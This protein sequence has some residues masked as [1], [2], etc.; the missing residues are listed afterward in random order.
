[1]TPHTSYQ[2]FPSQCLTKQTPKFQKQQIVFKDDVLEDPKREKRRLLQLSD[3]SF[4]GHHPFLAQQNL[5]E[6]F[7]GG[8]ANN[9]PSNDLAIPK[10]QKKE[11]RE[12]AEAEVRFIMDMCD[13]C[14][15]EPFQRALV[16][17]W[18]N[19]PKKLY[20]G[21]IVIPATPQCKAF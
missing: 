5:D 4:V 19:V 16:F 15:E 6:D 14:A 17:G 1:M 2:H 13:G 20:S 11:E 12:P 18:R 7:F 3:G 10:E 8:L 9:A 21:A